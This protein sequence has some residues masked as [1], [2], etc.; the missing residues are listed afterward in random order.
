MKTE[1]VEF[2][3]VEGVQPQ[4]AA[5]GG[6]VVPGPH[7]DLARWISSFAVVKITR[8][9]LGLI[10]VEQVAKGAEHEELLNSGHIGNRPGQI[11][12]HPH[13][14]MAVGQEKES[15]RNTSDAVGVV[16]RRLRDLIEA[17]V[18]VDDLDRLPGH[19]IRGR[20]PQHLAVP[21]VILPVD[22]ELRQLLLLE[23]AIRI[24]V[25]FY[26]RRNPIATRCI[27]V[28]GS[29]TTCEGPVRVGLHIDRRHLALQVPAEIGAA[30]GG[31]A[32]RH[33]FRRLLGDNVTVR[34]NEVRRVGDLIFGQQAVVGVVGG[35]RGGV[36]GAVPAEVADIED[37]VRG[38]VV[39]EVLGVIE[40]VVGRVEV[41][42]GDAIEAVVGPRNLVDDGRARAA[43]GPERLGDVRP[44]SVG[45][46]RV[47]VLGDFTAI[48]QVV[49]RT[50]GGALIFGLSKIS[51]V[52]R[53]N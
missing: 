12:Q 23:D 32:F 6:I 9:G 41:L 38:Q 17:D 28:R 37:A 24:G 19:H 43:V 34:R 8:R 25:G 46:D 40:R 51:S 18:V 1:R 4:E 20:F 53:W 36:D 3:A 30:D 29:L 22:Q 48:R 44:L 5:L 42:F 16:G 14:T 33:H 49:R 50:V 7:V 13:R 35:R 15:C 47:V 10:D 45:P 52:V 21:R 2:I 31:D 11:S 39:G 27:T 26:Q